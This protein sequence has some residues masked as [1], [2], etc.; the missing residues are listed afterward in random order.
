MDEYY[1]LPIT[2]SHLESQLQHLKK[3]KK[4]RTRNFLIF[5][6]VDA[7]APKFSGIQVTSHI[8]EAWLLL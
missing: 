8:Q 6:L 7:S 3:K 2:N 5:E 1:M 4:N